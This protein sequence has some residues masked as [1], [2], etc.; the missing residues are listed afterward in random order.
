M[1]VFGAPDYFD[2]ERVIHCFDRKS[3]L[4]A[5]IAIHNTVHGPSFGG[6]RM[7]QYASEADALSDVLRLSRGM[8]YKAAI[9]RLPVGGAKCVV[10]ADPATQKTHALLVSIAQMIERLGG[11][12]I[13]G[14][15]AG[16]TAADVG[17]M[18]QETQYVLGGE[19]GSGD[20]SP[21]TAFGVFRGIEAAVRHKLRRDNLEGVRIAIQGVG[22]VGAHLCRRLVAAGAQIMLSDINE[23]RV[24]VLSRELGCKPVAPDSIYSANCDLF[25]PCAFGGVLN[26]KTIQQLK[27]L[28]VAGAANNQLADAEC[29]VALHNRGILYAPDY[30]I[31]SA[32]LMSIVAESQERLHG[33]LGAMSRTYDNASTIYERLCEVFDESSRTGRR[34]ESVCDGIAEN[35]IYGQ[36]L[37]PDR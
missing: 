10:M 11:Q 19:D 33:D 36:S 26:R 37:S 21:V 22:A 13:S 23:E 24:A 34:P 17:V 6:C 9:L 12:Y 3:G 28:V 15:D 20:P 31:N 7:R 18:R 30:L 25:A 1:T 16:I 32:G 8:A 5:I 4:K 29:G 2:H 14:E 27:C 35:W